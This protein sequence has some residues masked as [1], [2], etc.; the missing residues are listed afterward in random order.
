MYFI[1]LHANLSLYFQDAL[2]FLISPDASPSCDDL[3]QYAGLEVDVTA[4][5]LTMILCAISSSG[6]R[7]SKVSS[8][9]YMWVRSTKILNYNYLRIYFERSCMLIPNIF[10]QIQIPIQ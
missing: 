1:S 2:T 4:T 3:R 5:Q 7:L 6:S 8:I 9:F 10:K